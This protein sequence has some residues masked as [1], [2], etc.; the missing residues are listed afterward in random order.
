[1]IRLGVLA[2][3]IQHIGSTAIPELPAKPVLDI[4]IAVRHLEDVQLCIAPLE[5]LGYQYF[6]DKDDR[7][8]HFFAKGDDSKRTHYIHMVEHESDAWRDYIHFRDTLVADSEDRTEYAQLKERLA[9]EYAD[10]RN[11]YT[12]QKAEFIDRINSKRT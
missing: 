4:G 12:S 5:L 10:A 2:V 6:G 1:M 8:D 9:C 7:G 3:D 11:S